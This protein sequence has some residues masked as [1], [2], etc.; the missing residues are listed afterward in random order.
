M[1]VPKLRFGEFSG[2]WCG[3]KIGDFVES[4]KGGAALTPSDFVPISDCEVIPKKA[5]TSGGKLITSL[6]TPTYCS[7]SFYQSNQQS[8][9]DN[10]YLITTL[11]D[12][13]P[14]GP[15][16]GYIVKYTE[17][18]KFILA[19]GVYG[20]KIK[21]NISGD[22]LTW[23]SNTD[24]YRKIMQKIMVGSTQVHVRTPDFF[25]VE[26]IVPAL[27]EQQKIADFLSAVD[28]KI[29]ALAAQKTALTQYKQG[30]MQRIFSQ[31]LRFKDD[32]GADYPEWETRVL[33]D[34]GQ[35][36]SGGTP[37]T[38]NK[39]FYDGGIP[40][41]KSGEINA[42]KSEQFISSM[43]LKKSS[44]KLVK[45]GDLLYALYGATS[46]E[47]SISKID[48]AIN[49]A[50]LCIRAIFDNVY[51]C[52]FLRMQK[53]RILAT[54]LQGGQGNLSADIVKSF[55]IPTPCINEQTKIAQ[56]LTELDDKINAVDAQIL[57]AQQWK[58]GLL[59]QM[60]V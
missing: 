55:I 39:K 7:E 15:S 47:V 10:S 11:R 35:F 33:G 19:Q 24:K 54:Y 41:I 13:V 42:D 60:F 57:S 6:E 40:F 38:S 58:Q 49:Q 30:M 3:Y 43:G 32:N 16:I 20:L 22:F 8:V 23:Y 25:D 36:F 52:N 37:L 1:N 26:L 21:N 50:V 34:E 56:F 48:G 4:Y 46:G 5:I 27:D 44:A 9:V 28:E 18:K 14:S 31:T 53:E 51:L 2:D 59:Q 45:K 12:L 29:T 17:N